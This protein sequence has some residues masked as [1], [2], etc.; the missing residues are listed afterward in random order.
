M[1]TLIVMFVYLHAVIY[2][3]THKRIDRNI[4]S[5]ECKR[6]LLSGI[7]EQNNVAFRTS[8]WRLGQMALHFQPLPLPI[9]TG[10]WMRVWE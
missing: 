9:G 2:S 10:W 8:Q 4:A 7:S 6:E 1:H 5:P 3:C